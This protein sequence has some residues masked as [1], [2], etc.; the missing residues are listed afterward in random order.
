MPKSKDAVSVRRARTL[1]KKLLRQTRE[2]WQHTSGVAARAAELADTVDPVDRRLLLAAAWLH[3]IGYAPTLRK[4]GFHPLDGGLY[5]RDHKWDQRLTA[6]VAHHS[7]ARFV[8]VERG[9]ADLMSMFPVRGLI[10]VGCV[11][12][13]RP[14]RRSAREA[15]D[16][17]VPDQRSNRPA[18][19]RLAERPCPR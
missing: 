14:N 13:R 17:R 7:G 2:R 12:L 5:L 4:T 10:A 15:H 8:P 9:F 11:V 6:L 1:S 18:R 3:D 16:D 19:A